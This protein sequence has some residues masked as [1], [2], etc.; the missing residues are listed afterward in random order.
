VTERDVPPSLNEAASALQ[1]GDLVV[2]F[3]EAALDGAGRGFLLH[4]AALATTETVATAIL[5]ARGITCFS[6]TPAQAMRLGLTLAG[7]Y[8][9]DHRG[10]LFLRS[11]EAADCD[12]TG[13]SAADRA[14][15]LRA[16]GHPDAGIASLKS[17][18]H[19]V[20]AMTSGP[21]RPHRAVADAAH[22]VL[23]ALTTHGIAAWTD[24]LNDDGEVADADWCEALAARLDLPCLS[25]A[26]F[27]RAHTLPTHPPLTSAPPHPKYDQSNQPV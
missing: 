17:P 13:I 8:R 24:I 12:G 1:A 15:T 22:D 3:D 27:A 7:E 20:P 9:P 16:A 10:P 5:H 21:G 6:V 23:S 19:V 2:V 14:R 4:A 18:G 25:L 11:V 26:A